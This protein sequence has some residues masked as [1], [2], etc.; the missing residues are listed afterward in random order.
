VPDGDLFKAIRRGDAS[1]VTDRIERFTPTG[2]LLASGAELPAD[3]VVTATGLKL[4]AFGGAE[5]SVDGAPV[6]LPDTMA[7]KGMLLSGVPNFVFTVGYTNASWT[8][9]A[10]L[11]AQYTMR[12]LKHLDDTG[13]KVFMPERQDDVKPE[14]F[15]DFAAGYV[16]RSL[17]EFPKQGSRAPWR[18]RQNYLRDVISLRRGKVTDDAMTFTKG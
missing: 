1:V 4:K 8:L 16:L 12:L 7:Y 9:K 10:D 14:P 15:M 2:L 17:H 13:T 11:V 6:H 18:L 3:V 5:L